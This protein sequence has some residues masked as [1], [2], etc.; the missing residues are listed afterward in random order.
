MTQIQSL[1]AAALIGVWWCVPGFSADTG[2]GVQRTASAPA[3]VGQAYPGLA[4]GALTH[5]RLAD[6]PEGILLKS[7]EITV[8]EKD[9][10][11]V[12]TDAP[13]KLREQLTKNAFF[14]LEHVAA[15]KLLLAIAKQDA[16]RAHRDIVKATDREVVDGYLKG[17][18]DSV[19]VSDEEVTAFYDQNKSMFSGAKLDSVKAQ[20]AQYLRQQKQQEAF[21]SLVESLGQ[22]MAIEVSASWVKAQSVLSRDNPVD[23]ARL[24][25]KPTMVDFGR[26]GCGPCD[27]MTPILATLKKKYDGK[28]NVLF[29]HVGEEEILG[30]RYGIESIPVQVFFDK[31]GKEVFRHTGFFPQEEVEKKLAEMGVK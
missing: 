30:M 12:G 17:A 28:A 18:L 4:S 25:G 9:I 27:M 2:A 26:D 1:V 29:V 6:L 14:V 11:A 24:S 21:R 3:T 16:A 22:K 19:Q 13:T 20:L 31:D 23:K 8:S 5:A 7:G 15:P 10:A